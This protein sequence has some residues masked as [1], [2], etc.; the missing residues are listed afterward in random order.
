MSEHPRERGLELGG[1][2]A[3]L[4]AVRAVIFGDP[5]QDL[6]ERRHAVARLVREIRPAEERP[7]IRRIQEHGERPAA[8]LLGDHLLRGLV[9]LVEVRPL[10]AVDLDVH[11]Q[12][13]HHR[14]GLG[15]LEGFV[16]HHVAPMAGRIA[17]RQ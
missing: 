13:I 17:H 8:R 10:F 1:L 3:D 7:P 4:C 5:L 16:G 15:V 11:E 2:L 14:R 12:A 9:D 6:L